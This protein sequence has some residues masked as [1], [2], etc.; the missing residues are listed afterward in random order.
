LIFPAPKQL[1]LDFVPGKMHP[2][3]FAVNE[4]RGVA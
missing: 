1:A 3:R 2:R 4:V